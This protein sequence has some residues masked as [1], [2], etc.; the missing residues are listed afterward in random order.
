MWQLIL[1][2]E[3]Y[4]VKKPVLTGLRVA[5]FWE[6]P[7]HN[8]MV[9]SK[10]L[11]KTKLWHFKSIFKDTYTVPTSKF[12]LIFLPLLI[13]YKRNRFYMSTLFTIWNW[14]KYLSFVPP[15]SVTTNVTAADLSERLWV[16]FE[17]CCCSGHTYG[18]TWGWHKGYVLWTI[19]AI[20][21]RSRYLLSYRTKITKI[22][23]KRFSPA[24]FLS[25][26]IGNNFGVG[27]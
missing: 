15:S 9:Q 20:F 8:T 5:P 17:K 4:I 2:G 11:L 7:S 13:N 14:A 24:T 3:K 18:H 27:M 12:L 19:F 21:P 23:N 1:F 6:I 10:A 22:S 25:L 16:K 26:K